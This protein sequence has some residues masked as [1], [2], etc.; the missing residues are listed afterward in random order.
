MLGSNGPRVTLQIPLSSFSNLGGGVEPSQSPVNVTSEALGAK[1]R[2]VTR[3][4]AETS[5]DF[6]RSPSDI[7]RRCPC[8]HMPAVTRREHCSKSVRLM[9]VT[10]EKLSVRTRKAHA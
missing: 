10:P 3:R 2:N 7:S 6:K 8:A 5:G 9:D 1:T 4:S